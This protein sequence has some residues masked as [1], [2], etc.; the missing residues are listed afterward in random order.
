V[1]K[2]FDSL[3]WGLLIKII[4]RRVNDGALIRLI[5]RW[6]NAGVMEGL[7][8]THPEKGTPQGG[9]ISPV[10]SNIFL[11]HVLDRW[12]VRDVK[13]RLQGRSFLIRFADDCAP[14]S[15]ME[16]EGR[17]LRVGLQGQALNRPKL[18]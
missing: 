8:L 16:D 13:P 1:A 17:P 14:R 3:D 2:F 11:H 18:R 5:G 15:A 7:T 9:V 12:Y 6:L 10:L 4:K